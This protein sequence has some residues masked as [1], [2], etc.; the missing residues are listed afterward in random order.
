MS[1]A[2][3]AVSGVLLSVLIPT[4]LAGPWAGVFVDRWDKR[5]T[6]IGMD[7]LRAALIVLLLLLTGLIPVFGVAP[8]DRLAVGEHLCRRRAHHAVLPVFRAGAGRAHRRC[9]HPGGTWP[10]QWA[11]PDDPASGRTDWTSARRPTL[12]H[13]GRALGIAGQCGIVR[14][15]VHPDFTRKGARLQLAVSRQANGGMPSV[16]CARDCVSLLRAVC[17]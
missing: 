8:G 4:I 1:W 11:R 16:K 10:G 5:R 15:V 13:P 3:L 17:W 7:I 9:R 14:C 2:P 12:F 6:M